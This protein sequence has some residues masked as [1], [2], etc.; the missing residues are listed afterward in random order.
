MDEA[1]QALA[2]ALRALA[3]RDHSVAE[4]ARK[5]RVAGTPEPL[6]QDTVGR[7]EEAGYLDDRRFARQ[8]ADFAVRS[9]RGY[10]VR[11]RL[12]LQRRGVA[13][14]IIAEVLAE[15]SAEYDEAETLAAL[16][17]RKFTGFSLTT[18]SDRE[19]RRVMQYLQR[20]GFSPAAIMQA[21]RAAEEC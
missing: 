10:G 16:L 3:R 21:F 14:E 7:L 1:K 6:V 19:K 11:L 9:G 8:W 13:A 15:L 2:R 5:L 12:E 18:A 17:A 20:R 4:L